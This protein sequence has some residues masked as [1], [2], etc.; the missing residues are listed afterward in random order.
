MFFP[1]WCLLHP[2]N[3]P[4]AEKSSHLLEAKGRF[5]WDAA[6]MQSSY[7]NWGHFFLPGVRDGEC[8]SE[9]KSRYMCVIMGEG[10][11]LVLHWDSMCTASPAHTCMCLSPCPTVSIMPIWLGQTPTPE[12]RSDCFR[13]RYVYKMSKAPSASPLCQGSCGSISQSEDNKFFCERKKKINPECSC[14]L[15]IVR[16]LSESQNP[17]IVWALIKHPQN[18]RSE[19]CA[20]QLRNIQPKFYSLWRQSRRAQEAWGV[21]SLGL[22]VP[23]M[24]SHQGENQD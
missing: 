15:P 12:H 23:V 3:I 7:F 18:R 9:S 4:P 16:I 10:H 8:V 2:G 1:P 6:Q 21:E 17:V 5:A 24:W 13:I 20:E 11:F 19:N 14:A 22:P